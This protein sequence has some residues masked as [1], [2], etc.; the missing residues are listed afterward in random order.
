MSDTRYRKRR[1]NRERKERRWRENDIQREGTQTEHSQ[2]QI[3]T[4][5]RERERERDQ[6]LIVKKCASGSKTP[7]VL[8][9]SGW[10]Y[11]GRRNGIEDFQIRRIARQ[12][13]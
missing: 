8:R 13:L 12:A 10:A 1:E 4:T 11:K 9:S 7:G 3:D 5:A 2:R 6:P